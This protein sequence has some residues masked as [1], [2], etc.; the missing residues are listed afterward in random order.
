MQGRACELFQQCPSFSR[1]EQQCIG[2][3][4]QAALEFQPA[5]DS[6]PGSFQ[7]IGP[8][9]EDAGWQLQDLLKPRP[10]WH[11]GA[12]DSSPSCGPL[13]DL[14]WVGASWGG[15]QGNLGFFFCVQLLVVRRLFVSTG[16]ERFSPTT[17]TKTPVL[18]ELA[19]PEENALWGQGLEPRA[20]QGDFQRLLE[21]SWLAVHQSLLKQY[22]HFSIAKIFL[23]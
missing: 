3:N 18:W 2:W 1:V 13:R 23:N 16:G 9:S 4:F 14:W 21:I 5:D 12:P 22:D 8:S 19:L 10:V 6:V 7:E 11:Q 17:T 15:H 20:V